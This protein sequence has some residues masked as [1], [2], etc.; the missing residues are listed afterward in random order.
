M[1]VEGSI[2]GHVAA[3]GDCSGLST[4][5]LLNQTERKTEFLIEPLPKAELGPDY[6]WEAVS[7]LPGLKRAPRAWDTYR[8]DVLTSSVQME[9]F[10]YD[11]CLFYRLK[12]SREQVEEKAGRHI[13]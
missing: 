5:H 9:Q 11:G 1:L 12:P 2:E 6:N 10:R 3:I 4:S 13:D 7:A 8:A